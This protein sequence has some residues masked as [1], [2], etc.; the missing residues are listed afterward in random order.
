[1]LHKCD[2]TKSLQNSLDFHFDLNVF[3]NFY[4]VAQFGGIYLSSGASKWVEGFP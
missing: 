3:R 4:N 2:P 1:M